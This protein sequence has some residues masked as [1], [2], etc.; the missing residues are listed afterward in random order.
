MYHGVMMIYSNALASKQAVTKVTVLFYNNS[1]P[2]A[3][4]HKKYR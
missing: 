4:T 1:I 2:N 3:W